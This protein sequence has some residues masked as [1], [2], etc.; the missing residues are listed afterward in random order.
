ML[1]QRTL[2][3]RQGDLATEIHFWQLLFKPLQQSR[4]DLV[5]EHIKAN[6]Q[7]KQDVKDG[8]AQLRPQRGRGRSYIDRMSGRGGDAND[9]VRRYEGVHTGLDGAPV[10]VSKGARRNAYPSQYQGRSVKLPSQA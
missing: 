9:F 4:E 6:Q 1:A 2:K 7:H 5:R 10:S 3:A 8:K